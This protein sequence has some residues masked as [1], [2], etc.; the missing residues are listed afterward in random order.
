MLT[1]LLRCLR[2]FH[3]LNYQWCVFIVVLLLLLLNVCEEW[4][5]CFACS[6]GKAEAIAEI[7]HNFNS[8]S[9]ALWGLK[10]FVSFLEQLTSSTIGQGKPSQG[11]LPL[12]LR[13]EYAADLS[14][15]LG[16]FSHW[17]TRTSPRYALCC[18]IQKMFCS[19]VGSVHRMWVGP[20]QLFSDLMDCLVHGLFWFLFRQTNYWNHWSNTLKG[21]MK[22]VK[23]W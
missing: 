1:R 21:Q 23:I 10:Q 11:N 18:W 14:V 15:A 20:G 2:V 22:Q 17:L 13:G 6:M 9:S 4:K 19:L 3:N 7:W 8:S 12:C 16:T 5:E